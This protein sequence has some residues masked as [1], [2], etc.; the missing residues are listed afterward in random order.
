MTKY[1]KIVQN[2]LN[3]PAT[4]TNHRQLPPTGKAG[5][6][7]P[8]AISVGVVLAGLVVLF[9]LYLPIGFVFFVIFAVILAIYEFASAVKNKSIN[10]PMLPMITGSVG[11]GICAYIL[12]PQAVLVAYFCALIVI[13]LW[14]FLEKHHENYLETISVSVLGMT[15]ISLLSSFVIMILN[16][17]MGNYL[18]IIFILMVIASDTGGYVFGV[19]FGKHP[20]SKK[21]SPN[22]SWEGFI[23]SLI[24]GSVSSIFLL[25]YIGISYINSALIAIVTTIV[26]VIGDL[27]ESLIKRDLKIKDMGHILPGHGGVLDRVDAILIASIPYITILFFIR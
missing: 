26:A 4:T 19:I 6:N 20:M 25:H 17:A 2:L 11:M 22:K 10:L 12:N 23:G 16:R 27:C 8:A 1:A 5:R 9:L 7:L 3:P 24:C 15:W 21:I 14:I 18:V 13:A